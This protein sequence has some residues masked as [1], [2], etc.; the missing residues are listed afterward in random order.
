MQ[1]LL[2][3]GLALNDAHA[4]VHSYIVSVFSCCKLSLAALVKHSTEKVD[5][6]GVT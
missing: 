4:S 3:S 6:S 5:P 2:F 1:E